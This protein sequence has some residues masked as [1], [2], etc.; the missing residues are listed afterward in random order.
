[1]TSPP[2]SRAETPISHRSLDFADT[3]SSSA[4]SSESLLDQGTKGVLV[5]HLSSM[6]GTSEHFPAMSSHNAP[7]PSGS[8]PPQS[9]FKMDEISPPKHIGN[10]A[11]LWSEMRF[12]RQTCVAQTE[13]RLAP[14]KQPSKSEEDDKEEIAVCQSPTAARIADTSTSPSAYNFSSDVSAVSSPA[15][16]DPYAPK[17]TDQG[18]LSP[19]QVQSHGEA[20]RASMDRFARDMYNSLFTRFMQSLQDHRLDLEHLSKLHQSGGLTE[21][22][23]KLL[24]MCMQNMASMF[25][26]KSSAAG[27]VIR[28]QNSSQCF[29][30]DSTDVEH[31]SDD[32][33]NTDRGK[34]PRSKNRTLQSDTTSPS[35][36]T[37][38]CE[39][40]DLAPLTANQGKTEDRHTVFSNLSGSQ[41]L[42]AKDVGERHSLLTGHIL[43]INS[44]IASA[45]Y[46]SSAK[47]TFAEADKEIDTGQDEDDDDIPDSQRTRYS[48]QADRVSALPAVIYTH[49]EEEEETDTGM[50]R[51]AS[52][53][54]SFSASKDQ[55]EH[56]DNE[57]TCEALTTRDESDECLEKDPS[58]FVAGDKEKE[59]KEKEDKDE[60]ELQMLSLKVPEDAENV[61]VPS[62]S[63]S[64]LYS[65]PLHHHY[66]CQRQ[67]L[68]LNAI[69]L[70][71]INTM[72]LTLLLVR[73]VL[74]HH[75][76]HL[77]NHHY[78]VSPT[79]F[80]AFVCSLF[81]SLF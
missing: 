33:C 35:K 2:L 15:E 31:Y 23:G 17:V 66:H 3:R 68:P 51:E 4:L 80:F 19:K 70:I 29:P 60:R 44:P 13:T 73:L 18:S 20:D 42:H 79:L 5:S 50:G 27:Y 41:S 25:G 47:Y 11:D 7:F 38:Q 78:Y 40:G 28:S 62:P 53:E 21:H 9:C 54:S 10:S 37:V 39:K 77:L 34:R 6:H 67:L 22:F 43:K 30:T 64:L 74:L 76:H 59:D 56:S 26:A 71:V 14:G 52:C 58:P 36:Q 72:S 1:M 55:D 81:F 45:T 8:T 57:E 12:H 49:K 69:I 16:Q 46:G 65:S 32:T 24:D 63:S 61:Q 75:H 48:P